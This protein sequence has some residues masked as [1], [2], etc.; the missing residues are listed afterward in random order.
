MRPRSGAFGSEEVVDLAAGEGAALDQGGG[1]G[2]DLVLVG[3]EDP[4][5]AGARGVRGSGD[6]SEQRIGVG[7]VESIGKYGYIAEEH[8]K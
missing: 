8:N 3:D 2:V 4:V 6:D 1:E 7:S 5:G